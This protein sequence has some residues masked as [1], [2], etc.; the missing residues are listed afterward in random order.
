MDEFLRKNAKGIVGLFL[1]AG[2]LS[3]IAA[4]GYAFFQV[5]FGSVDRGVAIALVVVA[6]VFVW[7]SSSGPQSR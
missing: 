5:V 1:I 3:L 4:L 6:I 7:R 2:V